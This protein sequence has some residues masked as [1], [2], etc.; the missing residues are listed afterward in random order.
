[1]DAN[2]KTRSD[3]IPGIVL[4][5]VHSLAF[6]L[7]AIPATVYTTSLTFKQAVG[8]TF[9]KYWVALWKKAVLIQDGYQADTEGAKLAKQT[10]KRTV[11]RKR[12]FFLSIRLSKLTKDFTTKLEDNVYE[13]MQESQ[14]VHMPSHLDEVI[15]AVSVTS[16]KRIPNKLL[17]TALFQPPREKLRLCEERAKSYSSSHELR[18]GLSLQAKQ[19]A[20]KAKEILANSIES[21]HHDNTEMIKCSI[22]LFYTM[23][24]ALL[25]LQKFK[26]ASENLI[27]AEKLSK[28]MLQCGNIIKDEWVEIQARIKLSFAQLYQSQKRSKEALPFYQKALEYTEVVKDEKSLDCVPVLRELAGVEQALG[29]HDAAINHFS[30]IVKHLVSIDAYQKAKQEKQITTFRFV[31]MGAAAFGPFAGV[32][33]RGPPLA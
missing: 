23:G 3:S 24:R 6:A 8:L 32:E 18:T 19:H 31:D 29:F 16:K 10:I 15:A 27:K 7:T 17:Q 21:P 25:A 14:E 20:E 33:D 11:K 2:N 1:M 22:E 4:R 5:A 9:V 28:E 12:S 13:N 30:Q 26:E